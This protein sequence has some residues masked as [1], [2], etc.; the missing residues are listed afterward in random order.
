M[1]SGILP[2]HRLEQA[3]KDGR[4][5]QSWGIA[6]PPAQLALLGP[7]IP[8][9]WEPGRGILLKRNPWYWQSAPN[10]RRLP[11]IDSLE[12]LTVPDPN[13]QLTLLVRHQ[14]DGL[15]DLPGKA[16]APL[17]AQ[18]CCRV[19]DGGP[20]L[21]PVALVFNL[22]ANVPDPKLAR[23]IRWF[24]KREF[25]QAVSLAIDRA[26]LVANVY[27]GLAQP[28]GTITSPADRS[29]ADPTPAPA[30]NVQQAR[31]DLQTAG[32]HFVRD[33]LTDSHGQPVRFSLIVP[34][35]SQERLRIANFIQE[36]LRR[37]GIALAV[38]PLDFNSYVDHMLHR[39][40]FDATLISFGFPD[41]DPNV[42]TSLWRLDGGLHLW[43]LHPVHPAPWESELDLLFREQMV[44]LS[45]TRRHTLY[46]RMQQIERTWPPFIPLVAPD[47]LIA[48]RPDI[49]GVQPALL[50]PHLLWNAQVLSWSPAH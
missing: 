18:H 40:D 27:A 23:R 47:V 46:H 11:L 16:A 34:S 42:E 10:G 20:G 25:R 24:E 12:L 41:T 26:N 43:N 1:A 38:V 44:T 8:E 49:Q 32:F 50:D 19:L 35:S 45:V 4:L 17:K 22:N 5:D 21:N 37:I 31:S 15:S 36:D 30:K 28:L 29:W 13:L 39:R 33:V 9:R 7:F 48:V 6:T 14:I 2:K 3:W